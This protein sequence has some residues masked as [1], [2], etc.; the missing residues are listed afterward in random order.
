MRKGI[1][2]LH[3]LKFCIKLIMIALKYGDE[4]EG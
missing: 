2:L 4:E 3:V 1:R